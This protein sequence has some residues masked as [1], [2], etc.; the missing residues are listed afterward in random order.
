MKLSNKNE[1]FWSNAMRNIRAVSFIAF[2]TLFFS[3]G[4]R[5]HDGPPLPEN[6]DLDTLMSEFAW[7]VNVEIETQ[8]ITD[9]LYG[10]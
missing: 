6:R 1:N 9:D 5:A 4:C 7:D 2:I 3:L 8:K 10:Y